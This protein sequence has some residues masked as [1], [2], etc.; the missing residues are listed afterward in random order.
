VNA[1]EQR[2][3]RWSLT[4]QVIRHYGYAS[5]VTRDALPC[6]PPP[7]GGLPPAAHGDRPMLQLG[8]G[9]REA[10]ACLELVA[11]IATKRELQPRRHRVRKSGHQVCQEACQIV[12]AVIEGEPPDLRMSLPLIEVGAPVTEQGGLAE[13]SRCGNSGTAACDLAEISY[14]GLMVSP[15]QTDREE[16]L[17]DV[18]ESTEQRMHSTADVLPHSES[19]HERADQLSARAQQ[20]R[21][22]A[23]QLRKSG[24]SSNED[25]VGGGPSPPA[26]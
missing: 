14:N 23:E 17:A 9:R 18:Q 6:S 12:V 22:R 15:E 5:A 24:P 25:A 4:V 3:P 16:Q 13:A 8:C 10:P 19:V 26:G 7:P 1:S 21:D 11:E 20:H 2:P